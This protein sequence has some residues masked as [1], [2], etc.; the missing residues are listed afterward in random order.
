MVIAAG[1]ARFII[2]QRVLRLATADR[3]GRP[4]VV[5]VC[6]A[7]HGDR[8]YIALDTKPKRVAPRALRR[9]R[10]LLENPRVALLAD[11]YEE[12]WSRLA[13]AILFGRAALLEEPGEQA[14]AV[15][16]LRE[17]YPQYQQMALEEAPII[18]VEVE[19]VASWRASQAPS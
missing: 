18:A 16:L 3:L 6:F 5:P 15:A 9:V 12:D 13:Y 14:L 10:N 11:V 2:A 8:V 19:R 17:R 7:L 1:D 4:H